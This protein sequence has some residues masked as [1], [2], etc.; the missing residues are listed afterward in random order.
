MINESYDM[1]KAKEIEQIEKC[2]TEL[3]Y[4]KSA[5]RKAYNYYHC[6]RDVDQFKHLEENYGVGVPTAVTFTPL[7]K[8]HIDVLV[9]EWLELEPDLHITCKDDVTIS[10]IMRDKNLKIDKALYDYISK[11]LQN[12]IVDVLLNSKNPVNDPYIEKELQRI[13]NDIDKS[14]VSEYEMAAQNIISYIR[15]SRDIDLKNKMRVLLTDL[16]IGGVCYYRVRPNGSKDNMIFDVLNPLDTFVERDSNSMFLNKSRRAVIRRRLTYDQV[17]EEF[18]DELSAEAINILK[19]DHRNKSRTNSY[20]HF[21]LHPTMEG[22]LDDGSKGSRYTPGILAGLEVMP[23]YD[24]DDNE[25][26]Y[27][28][29]NDIDVYECQWLEFDKKEERSVL[30]EGIKLGDN[31]YITRGEPEYYI[32]SK[33]KPRSCDLN[34]NGMFFNDRNGQPFSL[35]AATM[36]LQD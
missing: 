28:N 31:V 9:G 3:V 10:K 22:Y 19:E 20:R 34:I 29:L 35:I 18:G 16:L 23:L 4:D 6:K 36:S 15:N 27:Y 12:T 30:H 1:N 21:Y 11:Y 32:K 26:R 24:Q 13:Q 8:K 5:L 17:L 14:F 2:I 33:T 25:Y 7:I